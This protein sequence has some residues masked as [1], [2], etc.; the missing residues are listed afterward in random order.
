VDIG[1][2]GLQGDF[3]EHARALSDLGAA[4]RLVRRPEDL[5]GL[6]G[7]VL[8]GG[9]STTLAMLLESSGLRKPVGELLGSGVPV[10]GTCAGMILLSEVVT[11]GRPDQWTFG[12]LDLD[13]RR[14]GYGRQLQSFECDLDLTGF[15]TP[16]P[17]VFIRAPVVERVGDGVEVLAEVPDDGTGT[18]ASPAL[19]RQ[20]PILAAAFHPELTTDRR[21]HE[22]FVRMVRLFGRVGVEMFEKEGR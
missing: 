4:P 21:V 12:A 5:D 8:P 9:E 6:S 18:P 17:A 1:I 13:V 2:L 7:F 16:L 14:N 15:E 22:I 11:D 19:V 10:F 20:G 3:R